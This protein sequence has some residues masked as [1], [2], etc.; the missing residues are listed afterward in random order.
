MEC[1]CRGLRPRHFSGD[2]R[3][4]EAFAQHPQESLQND[5][6]RE[7]MLEFPHCSFFRS[8]CILQRLQVEPFWVELVVPPAPPEEAPAL[9]T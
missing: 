3:P 9:A 1:G 4:P 2:R 5:A 6:L 8:H 7:H